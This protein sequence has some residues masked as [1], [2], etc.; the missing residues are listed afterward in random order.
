MGLQVIVEELSNDLFPVNESI[1]EGHRWVSTCG[2]PVGEQLGDPLFDI[3][4]VD[5]VIC[6]GKVGLQHFF[7]AEVG[8]TICSG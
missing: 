4:K 2:V 5:D 6:I 1:A 3:G 8:H 7:Y